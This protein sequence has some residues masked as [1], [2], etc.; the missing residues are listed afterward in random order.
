M[1]IS[2]RCYMALVA[3]FLTMAAPR[4]EAQEPPTPEQLEK[5][6]VLF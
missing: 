4:T 5:D 3:T 6:P 1:M 2:A